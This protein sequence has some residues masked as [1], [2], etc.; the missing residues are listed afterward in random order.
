MSAIKV[1]KSLT[2]TDAMLTATSVAESSYSAWSSVTTYALDAR[3]YLAST[4]KVYQSLQAGNLNKD[5]LTQPLWWVEVESTNRWKMFDLS[6]STA[7][8]IGTTAYYEITPGQAVN[9]IAL[10]NFSGLST[11]RIRLTDAYFGVVYDKTTTITTEIEESSW[12]AWF[13]GART[14]TTQLIVSDLPSYP[15]AVL[16]VDFTAA[17]SATIGV[18]T[19]GTQASIGM[20]VR[21]GARLGMQDYSRKERDDWGNTVL[22]QRAYAKRLSIDVALENQYLDATYTTLTSLRATPC[23]WIISD[24][25]ESL[26]LFG[27]FN[28][29]EINIAYADYSDCSIDLESLT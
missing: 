24:A 5:P 23:L 22:V 20:G 19:F 9:S 15:N 14:E 8:S 7:T 18:L 17:V 26:V 11:I 4:H 12:Y 16:R 3:V 1:I 13:F 21:H 29:F 27:F 6:S 28:N 2:L 25:Y 10:L